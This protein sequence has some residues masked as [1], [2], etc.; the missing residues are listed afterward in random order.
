MEQYEARTADRCGTGKECCALRVLEAEC[1]SGT[2]N[3]SKLLF[4]KLAMKS[5]LSCEL[6]YIEYCWAALK[7]YTREK[8]L[9][10]MNSVDIKTNGI[11]KTV[12]RDG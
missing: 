3:Q 10:A 6:N 2:R 4:F 12:V 9:E 5:L 11:L 7:R 1:D 8:I